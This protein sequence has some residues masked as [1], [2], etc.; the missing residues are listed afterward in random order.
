VCAGEG[1]GQHNEDMASGTAVM[2]SAFATAGGGVGV[3]YANTTF[4]N[5]GLLEF[6]LAD[7]E[8]VVVQVRFPQG[9]RIQPGRLLSHL[10]RATNIHRLLSRFSAPGFSC[11]GRL[12]PIYAGWS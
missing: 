1:E 11:S 9:N 2:M 7:L 10:A 12:S 8:G 5:L 4:R 3:A 6:E